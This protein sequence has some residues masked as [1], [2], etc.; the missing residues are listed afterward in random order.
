[1]CPCCCCYWRAASETSALGGVVQLKRLCLA[2]YPIPAARESSNKIKQYKTVATGWVSSNKINLWKYQHN[3]ERRK[4]I[5]LLKQGFYKQN[6][7]MGTCIKQNK[8]SICKV[9]VV[10]ERLQAFVLI[11]SLWNFNIS[12]FQ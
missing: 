3:S 10:L 4:E 12:F 2:A 1:M 9:A 7:L 6:E 11:F 8:Q 5:C